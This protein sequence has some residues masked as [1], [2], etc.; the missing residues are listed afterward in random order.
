MA[1]K[2]RTNSPDGFLARCVLRAAKP[3]YAKA[4]GKYLA[5]MW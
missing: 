3:P 2:V 4:M 1:D 5:T